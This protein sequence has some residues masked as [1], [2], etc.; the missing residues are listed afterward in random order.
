MY[1]FQYTDKHLSVI[2]NAEAITSYIT[3]EKT[4]VPLLRWITKSSFGDLTAWTEYVQESY[5]TK[6]G[7]YVFMA[8]RN[9]RGLVMNW[10][11]IPDI[12]KTYILEDEVTVID[13]LSL[14]DLELTTRLNNAL[15]RFGIFDIASLK[16]LKLSDVKEIPNIGKKAFN[17]FI[18]ACEKAKIKLQ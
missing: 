13:E 18:Y 16:K 8:V 17:D 10:D 12:T 11:Q 7:L 3:D 2:P 9:S 5:D 15:I 1:K 14:K 4:G 6:D